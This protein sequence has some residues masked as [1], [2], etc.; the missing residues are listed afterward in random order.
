MLLFRVCSVLHFL[1][2]TVTYKKGR[3]LGVVVMKGGL[4]GR[5]VGVI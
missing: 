1:I 2:Q 5:G 4:W 3:E